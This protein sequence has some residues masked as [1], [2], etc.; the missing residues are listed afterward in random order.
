LTAIANPYVVDNL[1]VDGVPD[2]KRFL[3]AANLVGPGRR[4]PIIAKITCYLK[5]FQLFHVGSIKP[6]SLK[7]TCFQ[8]VIEISRRT[9][10]FIT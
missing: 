3:E 9:G 10:Y 5:R 2:L 6:G 1:F 4:L 8:Y 7:D